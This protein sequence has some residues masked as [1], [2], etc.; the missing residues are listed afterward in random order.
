MSPWPDGSCSGFPDVLGPPFEQL[1]LPLG[2][3]DESGPLVATLVRSM[4]NPG[5]VAPG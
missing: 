4:P 5:S 3:D 1:T 2:V